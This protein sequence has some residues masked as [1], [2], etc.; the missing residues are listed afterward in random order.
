MFVYENLEGGQK[1]FISNRENEVLVA[2]FDP[3]K[4]SEDL[5]VPLNE[6]INVQ[7]LYFDYKGES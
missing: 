5:E 2:T 7:P 4:K 3:S 1:R 6:T